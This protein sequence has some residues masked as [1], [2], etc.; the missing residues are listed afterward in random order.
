M[1]E[2]EIIVLADDFKS[3]SMACGVT[4]DDFDAVGFAKAIR[5][6]T[7]EEAAKSFERF[8]GRG[9]ELDAG[10]AADSIRAL[11]RQ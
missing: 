2:E 7:L 4:V 6:A 11:T 9:D 1:T 8:F 5:N 10:Y 3:T